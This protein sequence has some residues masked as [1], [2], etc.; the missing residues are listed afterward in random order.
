MSGSKS[1]ILEQSIRLYQQYYPERHNTRENVSRTL[2]EDFDARD[3]VCRIRRRRTVVPAN[4]V[5]TWSIDTFREPIVLDIRHDSEA[6]PRS[7]TSYS[8][9]QPKSFMYVMGVRNYRRK[10]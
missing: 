3:N 6:V 9:T 7:Q 4:E 10:I 5:P 2:T 8:T 1:M